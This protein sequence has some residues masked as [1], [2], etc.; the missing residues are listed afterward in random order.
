MFS[1]CRHR[2]RARRAA[3]A[4]SLLT[5]AAVRG[6]AQHAGHEG[7]TMPSDDGRATLH[8]MAQAIPLVTRVDRSPGGGART[9][10]ALAQTLLMARAAWWQGRAMLAATFD[11]EGLTMR[12][13]ELS[14]G[15]FGEGFADRRH[16]H[17]YLHELMLGGLAHAGPASLS[18]SG[19]RGFAPFGT[20]DPMVRPFAKYPINH[21][22]AQI[23]ERGI[24]VGA[25]RLGPAIL[26]AA[27]FT[28]E[29]PQHPSSLP[30]ARRFGDSWSL[31]GTI[32]PLAGAELQAS[33]ARLSSPE[34]PNGFGLDQRKRSVS[35]RVASPGGR[36]ALVEW[37][38][39]V[40]YDHARREDAFSYESALA[41]AALPIGRFG[42]ALRLEQTDRPEEE[43]LPDPFRTARPA[44]DLHIAG[45]TRWRTAS[46]AVSV[47]AV[48][49]S[50][51]AGV[52]FLELCRLAATARDART[53]F[54]PEIVYGRTRFWMLTGGVRIRVGAAHPRMGRYGVAIP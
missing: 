45:I 2:S 5:L 18:L 33:Y 54:D 22:L 37:A 8:V 38:R 3:A 39:T 51:V 50:T 40:E 42:V 30:L 53:L 34:V 20:D 28:G 44:T 10:P 35:A 9:E 32:V 6:S 41:E 12:E 31:R 4:A 19:G 47:P 16:P 14:L 26:E 29:E 24:V 17:T 43:R 48:T 1:R 7:M 36:Y 27:T 21:H 49:W 13:G 15:A 11:A 52:P 23:L 46:V 25:A